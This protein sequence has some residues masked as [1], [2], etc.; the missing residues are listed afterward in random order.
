MEL[1]IPYDFLFDTKSPTKLPLL[2]KKPDKCNANVD[3]ILISIN[4]RI[5]FEE[6]EGNKETAAQFIERAEKSKKEILSTAPKNFS[7]V[8]FMTNE[9]AEDKVENYSGN[10]LV[11]LSHSETKLGTLL[12]MSAI[13][14]FLSN[15][16]EDKSL[17]I[18][19]FPSKLN[20]TEVSEGRNVRMSRKKTDKRHQRGV[21]DCLRG[22]Y[23]KPSRNKKPLPTACSPGGYLI[24]YR[25]LQKIQKV[26]EQTKPHLNPEMAITGIFREKAALKIHDGTPTVKIPG[27]HSIMKKQPN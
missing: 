2:L 5:N 15:C 16:S 18:T 24:S 9:F 26:S 7:E 17:I 22:F 21:V 27:R 25:D 14:W 4:A 13:D 12:A 8:Y 20:L 19:D 10:F 23:E 6:N 1:A 3:T 11:A